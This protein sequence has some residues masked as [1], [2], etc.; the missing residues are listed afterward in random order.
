MTEASFDMYHTVPAVLEIVLLV[1]FFCNIVHRFQPAPPFWSPI[2]LVAGVYNSTGQ[3]TYS[4]IA[5]I[6]SVM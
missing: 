4:C 6:D 2:V 3:I 1:L 5:S